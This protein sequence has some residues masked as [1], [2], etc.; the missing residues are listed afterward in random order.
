MKFKYEYKCIAQSNSSALVSVS[1]D[2]VKRFH[3]VLDYLGNLKEKKEKIT[4]Y[5]RNFKEL[6]TKLKQ[7]ILL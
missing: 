1:L 7:K 3:K 5:F 4:D 2:Q 6:G